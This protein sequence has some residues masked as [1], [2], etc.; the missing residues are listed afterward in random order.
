MALKFLKKHYDRPLVTDSGILI[1][2]PATNCEGRHAMQ[3]DLAT[4]E[5]NPRAVIVKLL[6]N[7][8]RLISRHT[9]RQY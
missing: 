4:L 2:V 9:I 3:N 7:D 5:N 8:P 1:H 6:E